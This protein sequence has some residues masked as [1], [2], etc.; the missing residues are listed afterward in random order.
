MNP[1]GRVMA[2]MVGSSITFTLMGTLASEFRARFCAR[3]LTY[4]LTTGSLISFG[5]VNL[6]G[7]LL[8]DCDL[9]FLGNNAAVRNPAVTDI[10]DVVLLIFRSQRQCGKEEQRN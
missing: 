8:P 1:P 7:I 10:V 2:L 9:L 6:V 3:R 4:S 5:M